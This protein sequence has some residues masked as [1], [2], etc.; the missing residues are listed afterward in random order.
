MVHFYN[1]PVREVFSILNSSE[2]G[3]SSAEA[4]N[5]LLEYGVNVLPREKRISVF[6]IF[7]SQFK[8]ALLILLIF[9]GLISLL[10]GEFLEAA[11]IFGIVLLNAVLGFVQEFRAERA[12]EALERLAAP[13]AKVL[14]DG[15]EIK[16]PARELVP[17]DVLLLEAGDIVPADSRI[18]NVS[19]LQIDEASLTGESVPSKKIVDIFKLGTSVADQ[20]NIAFMHTV[21]TYGKGRCVV[22]ATGGQTEMGKIS[23]SIQTTADVESPLQAKFKALARQIGVITVILIL[24]VFFSGILQGSLSFSRMLVFALALTV[25][26]I[27]NS[28][29]VI[30]TVSLSMGARRLVKKNLLV[31]K[32][33]AVETL[34]SVTVICSDK[35]GTMTKNE[36]TVTQVFVNGKILSVSGAGYVPKGGFFADGKQVDSKNAELLFKIGCLCNNSRLFLKNGQWSIVGDPTEGALVVLGRKGLIDDDE[37]RHQFVFVEELP[38]DSE[39]KRMTVICRNSINK[40]VEAFVKG[41]PEL[42]LDLCSG[43]LENGKVRK[44]TKADKARVLSVQ[45]SFAKSALRNLGFA[46]RDVSK[47]KSYSVESVERD[48]VFV[49]LAGMIDPPRDEVKGAIEQC[50]SAGI[51]VIMIT[52]DNAVTARAVGEAVG[53]MKADGVVLTGNELDSMSDAELFSVIDRVCIVARA[54]PIQKI[55]IVDVLQRHGHIVAMTGDGVNDAPALKKADIGIAMGITGSDVAKEVAKAVLIDDNFATI[56]NAVAEGRNIFDKMIKSATYLLSCNSGEIVS[57]FSAILLNFPV[58]MVPLQLLAM[59]LLTDDFPALGLGLEKSE[60]NVMNVP[61]RSPKKRPLGRWNVFAIV[62]FGLIMGSG[63]LFVFAEYKDFDL[64]RAQTMAFTTLVMFQMFA[65]LSIRTS[66]HSFSDINPFSN[67]WILGAILLSVGL[68]LA[69]VY[70]PPLQLV[71]STTS[72]TLAEWLKITAVASIGFIGMELSKLFTHKI[73]NS[74]ED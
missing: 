73:D 66:K 24:I 33:L 58:P 41:A 43:I 10:L 34:G 21:V 64:V 38:F 55:R 71:F 60:S 62:V 18:F 1:L 8:N 19:S 47:L 30:V 35:T 26:T 15:V 48:L 22:I 49:G 52:G 4:K 5:R 36:M 42:L 29:P 25:S 37:L 2:N 13:I 6:G 14:R 74:H 67:L 31:K 16:I 56:V 45:D 40:K 61:P 50:E 23:F 63:T 3:L 54:L 20:E 57:V 39:R 28:L 9:A 69:I 51:K 53:L 12:V 27:P 11:V 59:S 44:I 72:L 68:Q 46:Y 7:F 17:G 32:L 65:V 70:F